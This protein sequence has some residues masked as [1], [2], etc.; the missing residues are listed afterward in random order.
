MILVVS[1]RG[2]DNP[3]LSLLSS[4]PRVAVSPGHTDLETPTL[5][6]GSTSRPEDDGGRA[7]CSTLWSPGRA[8]L[9][10]SRRKELRMRGDLDLALRLCLLL[11]SAS[12][13][14]PAGGYLTVTI[15]T[16]HPVVIGDAVT[17][18][19]FFRTDGNLR[20]I[21]WFR[22]GSQVQLLPAPCRPASQQ[23]AVFRLTLTVHNQ[24]D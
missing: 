14:H 22:M 5:L 6:V 8:R 12:C 23:Q 19:C 15:E 1:P 24:T 20:E 17:I 18:K 16:L 10:G 13:L 7:R 11:L 2:H 21:V 9:P 4:E 3:L